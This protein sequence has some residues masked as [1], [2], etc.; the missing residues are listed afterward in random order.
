MKKIVTTKNHNRYKILKD[1]S[2]YITSIDKGSV[3]DNWHKIG[4]THSLEDAI[5]LIKA[6]SNSDIKE[7]RDKS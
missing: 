7:I 4:T 3:F 6:D 2:R 5:S 1:G